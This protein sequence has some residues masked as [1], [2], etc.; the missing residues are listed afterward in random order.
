MVHFVSCERNILNHEKWKRLGEGDP[1]PELS[2]R[3]GMLPGYQVYV[4]EEW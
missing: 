2:E 4:V 3:D 1:L